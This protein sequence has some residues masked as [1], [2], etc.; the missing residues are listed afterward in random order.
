LRVQGSRDQEADQI[1]V[2]VVDDQAKP[3]EAVVAGFER[4]PGFSVSEARSLAEARTMLDGVD[5]AILDLGLPDGSGADLIAELRAVNPGAIAV[6]LTSSIDPAEAER[7]RARGA[8]AALNKLDGF[9]EVAAKS[10]GSWAARHPDAAHT[11]RA[12][13]SRRSRERPAPGVASP[14]LPATTRKWRGW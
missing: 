11:A 14:S 3:R 7:A 1:R 13:P 2:L 9:D 5:V 12:Q 6:G 8:A 4:E 10:S